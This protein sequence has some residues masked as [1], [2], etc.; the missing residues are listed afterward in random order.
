MQ[1]GAMTTPRQKSSIVSGI[2]A[3]SARKAAR[4]TSVADE[5]PLGNVARTLAN[6]MAD[7][8]AARS[9]SPDAPQPTPVE[10]ALQRRLEAAIKLNKEVS[11][12]ALRCAATPALNAR[13]AT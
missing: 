1:R 11:D 6:E 3:Q 8:D 4:R 12:Q 10:E 2:F 13:D 7:S 5:L 9:P